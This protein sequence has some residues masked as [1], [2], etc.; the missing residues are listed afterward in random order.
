MRLERF[1]ELHSYEL[2]N[3]SN[4]NCM[5]LWLIVALRISVDR[6]AKG[7][8]FLKM[9]IEWNRKKNHKCT[10]FESRDF[11]RNFRSSNKISEQLKSFQQPSQSHAM[12]QRLIFHFGCIIV[13]FFRV[14][15]IKAL[16]L[17]AGVPNVSF[18]GNCAK[19]TQ[20]NYILWYIGAKNL[21]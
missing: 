16:F 14:E 3:Y 13:Y 21:F 7:T 8:R 4:N 12:V 10:M 1:T 6:F 20:S 9:K 19:I 11:I 2:H 15:M 5:R 18:Y 17:D